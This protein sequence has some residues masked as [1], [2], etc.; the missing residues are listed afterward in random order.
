[1]A[2]VTVGHILNID[3]GALESLVRQRSSLRVVAARSRTRLAR[4]LI[5]TSRESLYFTLHDKSRIM[6]RGMHVCPNR[7]R[8][9]GLT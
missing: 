4:H 9:A 8:P 3:G 1:M 2:R 6:K 5:D 7:P